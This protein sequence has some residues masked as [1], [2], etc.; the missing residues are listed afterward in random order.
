MREALLYKK[1][2][3]REGDKKNNYLFS[4]LLLLRGPATP[5][6]PLVVPWTIYIL[7]PYFNVAVDAL[8]PETD[9]TLISNKKKLKKN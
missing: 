1:K 6:P 8:G 5:P 4:S 3:V 2:Q 7:G 9:F